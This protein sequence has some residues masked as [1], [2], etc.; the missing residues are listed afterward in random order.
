MNEKTF[1]PHDTEIYE[2]DTRIL[3]LFLRILIL[4]VV[5]LT[6]TALIV[7]FFN[8][9]FLAIFLA[10][11]AGLI[12]A[13]TYMIWLLRDLKLTIQ[14]E[15]LNFKNF[16]IGIILVAGIYGLVLLILIFGSQIPWFD[17]Y[18]VNQSEDPYL[19]YGY[20]IPSL[21]LKVTSTIISALAF[22]LFTMYYDLRKINFDLIKAH[23]QKKSPSEIYFLKE[24]FVGQYS[25]RIL[26]KIMGFIVV[27]GASMI[28]Y[29]TEGFLIILPIM[30]MLFVPFS[31]VLLIAILIQ[32]NHVKKSLKYEFILENTKICTNCKKIALFSASYCGECGKP[33]ESSYQFYDSMNK[34]Q[35]CYSINPRNYRYC[36]YC[37]NN[38][39]VKG[40]EAKRRLGTRT[41]KR[42]LLRKK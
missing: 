29:S 35:N 25:S 2:V 10:V 3:D 42:V 16:G 8:L 20:T 9:A 34:C 13:F 28:P 31:V 39:K 21:Y 33:F 23:K 6:I 37:G 5:A 19:I 32:K 15:K 30:L 14:L 24:E 1:K 18:I 38:I 40:S 4:C 11:V 17:Y 41:I 7:N 12:L 26:Y 36:I 27:I 22:F